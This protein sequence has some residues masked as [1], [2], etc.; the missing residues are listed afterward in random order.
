VKHSFPGKALF[1]LAVA[2]LLWGSAPVGIRVGL[3]GYAPAQLTLLRFGIGS[4]A[5]TAYGLFAGMH[6][7][8]RGSLLKLV[9]A[10][11]TGITFYNVVLN[12]GLLTVSAGTASFLIASTPVWT[13]LLA[14]VVL[15][16]R[17]SMRGWAGIF[18]SFVGIGLIANERG[19]GLHF[20][21]G[22]IIIVVG[23]VS[24]A[25][26]MILQKQLLAHYEALDFTC[27]SFWA[28]TLLTI[29]LGRGL[30][31]AMRTA[32]ADATWAVIYLGL[33]PAALANVAWAYAMA[34]APASRVSSFLYLMPVATV[35]IA[36]AW[37]HEVPTALTLVGGALALAGV[38]MVNLWGKTAVPI[39]PTAGQAEAAD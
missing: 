5:L 22:A 2:V 25:V 18:V 13:A 7:P 38:C 8:A 19:H 24:Y 10:G 29:P 14:I 17:L 15:G 4:I 3:K 30:V 16:E 35:L 33:F 20:S 21:S 1:A 36:G 31:A 23:A 27:Y 9:L 11:A 34:H 28:G 39:V 12:Y 26:Y 37:L 32:P 6:L